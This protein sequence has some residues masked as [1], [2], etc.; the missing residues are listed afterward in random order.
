MKILRH[1][2]DFPAEFK[3]AVI[4]IGNFD[5]VHLGHMGVIG[6]ARRIAEASDIPWG[7]MTFEPHPRAFFQPD[8]PSF[9]ITPLRA[10]SHAVV[11]L[12]A[13]FM[14]ALRF[15]KELAAMPAEDFVQSVLMDNLGI[16][17]IVCGYD[18]SFGKG[19]TGDPEFLL[20]MGKELG[21]GMT[22]VGA[23]SDES[24][25]VYSS[26][27]T[28]E[29]LKQGDL[30]Q[31]ANLLGRPYEIAGRVQHGDKRGRTIG[32]PTANIHMEEYMDPARGIY[33]VR[34][35]LDK[36][37]SLDPPV[38]INGVANLGIRPMFETAESVLEVYLFDFDG[39]LYDQHMRIQLLEYIRPE[40]KFD[41]LDELVTA[42]E[43]DC[44][45]AREILAQYGDRG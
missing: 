7:V 6:E 14:I 8:Q 11:P 26:T 28:R 17:H 23:I 13:D 29:A 40:M 43:A 5:G 18:F 25:T 39:E 19:R 21:F 2:D 12:G 45:K 44:I 10:K 9:R 37:E 30:E 4:A 15:D 34:A 42:I 33:A 1:F 22:A 36:P 27:R 16:H 41:G 3:G 24:D 20:H 38:W 31:V 35:A 32:F